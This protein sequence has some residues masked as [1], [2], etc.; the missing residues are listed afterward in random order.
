MT[1]P[2]LGPCRCEIVDHDGPFSTLSPLARFDT[3]SGRI[4]IPHEHS[5]FRP[6]ACADCD[7]PS[8]R[9]PGTVENPPQT[10]PAAPQRRAVVTLAA[11]L[12]FAH[13]R[14]AQHAEWLDT[15]V[16]G[17]RT[18]TADRPDHPLAICYLADTL[19]QNWPQHLDIHE[20]LALAL[21][22]LA[23]AASPSAAEKF[24]AAVKRR[25]SRR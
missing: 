14:V 20:V 2:E 15:V 4:F 6:H 10:D 21:R 13:E 12:D 9:A 16:D 25:A 11:E 7:C 24:V 5:D 19:E 23:S 22:R 8:W 18:N 1:A 3:Q 17:L